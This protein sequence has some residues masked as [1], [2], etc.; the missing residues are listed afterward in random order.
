MLL[1]THSISA[2]VMGEKLDDPIL[3][4][5]LGIVLHFV[6]DAIPHFD[7]TDAGKLTPRQLLLILIDGLIGLMILY[8]IFHRSEHRI[9]LMAGVAGGIL[10]DLLDNIPLWEKQFRKTKFGKLFHHWHD[11]IQRKK[12]KPLWGIAVQVLIIILSVYLFLNF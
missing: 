4:F 7:T 6:L 10:P 11:I 12:L 9:S 2:G 5:L 8:L 1:A 3:A